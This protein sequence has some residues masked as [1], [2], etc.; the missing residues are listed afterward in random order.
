MKAVA[1]QTDLKSHHIDH[2]GPLAIAKGFPILFVDKKEYSIAKKYYPGLDARLVSWEN[3]HPLCIQDEYDTIFTSICVPREDFHALYSE[4]MRYI[5]TSHGNSDKGHNTNELECFSYPDHVLIY[6]QRMID[7]LKEKDVFDRLRSYSVVGNVRYQYYLSHKAFFDALVEEEVFGHF[8]QR[9]KRILYAPTWDAFDGTFF[10][11]EKALFE[12]IPPDFQLIVK[13][14]PFFVEE[15][16]GK[17]IRLINRFE[18][19]ENVLI[20]QEYPLIYPLLAGIDIYLGDIS[21][22]GYDFLAFNRPMFFLNKKQEPLYLHQ[23]GT[24]LPFDA[25]YEGILAG[26]ETD[27]ERFQ[28]VRERLFRYTFQ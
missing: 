24:T 7:F 19:S 27:A 9:K 16:L 22:V 15:N 17:V 10:E 4:K 13:L 18:N 25:I 23:S 20:L 3:V 14:H 11:A 28:A 26:L 12:N 5:F 2:M 8:K 6:G 21:S 1:L